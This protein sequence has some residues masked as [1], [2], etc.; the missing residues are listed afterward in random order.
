MRRLWMGLL[1]LSVLS[2]RA[3]A[4]LTSVGLDKSLYTSDFMMG[5][6]VVSV[7]FPES[8]G[9]LDPNIENWTEERKSQVL[10]EIMNGLDWWTQQNTKSPLSF[11]FV[12]QTVTTKYE[13][14]TRPYYDEAL[15]IPE[16]MGKLGY[17]GGSRWDLTRRYV[18]DLRTQHNA[19]WGFVA[20]V[21]DSQADVNGKLA[22][23]YFAYAYLGGPFLV[24]TYDNNGY[25]ISN[26]DVVVAHEAGHIFHAL[27]QYAGASSPNAYSA[28]YFPTINGNHQ[29]ASTANEPNSIMRGGIRWGLDQWSRKM[30]GWNDTNSNGADDI[31]D[32]SPT[33]SV[34]Q[35]SQATSNGGTGFS[36]TAKVNVLPRQNNANGY[37]FTLDT[38]SS[39]EYRYGNQVWSPA[40]P[41]D[42]AFNAA[43]ESFHIEIAANQQTVGSQV[44]INAADLDVRVV[45]LYSTY[46]GSSGSG[47][48][49]G[50]VTNAHPFPNP[51]KPNSN[52]G[53]SSVVFTSL[54]PGAKVQVF[55]PAGEPV[56]EQTWDG[57]GQGVQW[58]TVNEADSG[59]Y[60]FMISAQNGDK[61]KGK[62]A[63]IR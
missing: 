24:M 8:D 10:S 55:T 23:G 53:H 11:T 16:I 17:S 40:Q 61:K 39:V 58:T 45:T 12:S 47:S 25:G 34:S 21:L 5:N 13:P 3:E 48:G 31:L 20:F 9:T 38:I 62:I 33:V 44:V 46:V 30:I 27:D 49:S 29:Y 41:Q 15:W 36:G 7:I 6:V 1:C 63:I 57:Q 18:N 42:G 59:M 22:D 28:G 52:L 26:M 2:I 35:Q 56:F 51:Y 19:D 4:A 14:I 43:E 37:G 60:Y 32:R 50:S 54:T